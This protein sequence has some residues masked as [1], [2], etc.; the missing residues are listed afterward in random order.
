MG[1]ATLHLTGA[2]ALLQ[3]AMGVSHAAI[4]ED[5]EVE[6]ESYYSALQVDAHIEEVIATNDTDSPYFSQSDVYST[7][8]KSGSPTK[9]AWTVKIDMNII[10]HNIHNAS[11]NVVTSSTLK[12]YT[13]LLVL[14]LM[15]ESLRKYVLHLS[16]MWIFQN[17]FQHRSWI[18]VI[19][20]T[21]LL[22]TPNPQLSSSNT[23]NRTKNACFSHTSIWMGHQKMREGEVVTS[24]CTI[25]EETLK[26]LY[27]KNISFATIPTLF[28]SQS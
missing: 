15:L 5:Q 21:S 7:N 19:A 24:A 12:E 3:E 23:Q 28:T 25:D 6:A 20:S 18:N 8:F 10:N 14:Y 16:S 17:G 11:K 1:L 2:T 22:E 13:Q 9:Q 26:Q 4:T 27:I